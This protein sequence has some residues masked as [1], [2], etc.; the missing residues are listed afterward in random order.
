MLDVCLYNVIMKKISILTLSF[1]ILLLQGCV[2]TE[3]VDELIP[4]QRA[5]LSSRSSDNI[6]M[7]GTD[8]Q[9]AFGQVDWTNA[10]ASSDVDNFLNENPATDVYTYDGQGAKFKILYG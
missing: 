5:E 3:T 6:Y 4:E 10:D 8:N 9:T 1:I 2:M 7:T